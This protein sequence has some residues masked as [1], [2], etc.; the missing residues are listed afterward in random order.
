MSTLRIEKG[1]GTKWRSWAVVVRLLWYFRRNV[2]R[3][4]TFRSTV[5]RSNLL[6]DHYERGGRVLGTL[7]FI[8]GMSAL[9]REDPRVVHL[10]EALAAVGYRVLIPDF[11]S[12]RALEIRREQPDEVLA[13]LETLAKDRQ[14]VPG[15]FSL[16]AVSF[17]G[18]FALRAACN[19]RLAPRVCGLC[20]IGGYYD[21]GAVSSF[22]IRAKRADPYGR[23]L[24]LR[25]YYREVR[26]Q[27]EPFH[28]VLDRCISQNIEQKDSWSA[29]QALDRSD[30]VEALVY[31]KLTDPVERESLDEKVIRAFAEGWRGYRSKLDFVYQDTP[32]FLIHGRDDRLIPSGESKRLAR[33]LADQKI[34]AYL[35]IT[36]FLSHGDSAIRLIQWLELFR[37]LRGFAWFFQSGARVKREDPGTGSG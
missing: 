9:G 27:D 14:L 2:S 37:L 11:P 28:Q 36:R 24:V 32:V 25:S 17:S 3:R 31:R 13:L 30:P 7:I 35:C 1:A 6:L 23:L 33:R 21:V 26:P 12:I 8:H 20:L 29:D 15:V 18:V 22:L 5:R 10:A 16:I 4:T 19:K 34:P